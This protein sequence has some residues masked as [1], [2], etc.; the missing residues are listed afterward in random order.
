MT[1]AHPGYC[2]RGHKLTSETQYLRTKACKLCA[3]KRVARF[4]QTHP[5]Y[6]KK[7]RAGHRDRTSVHSQDARLKLR[8]EFLDAYGGKC[9]CCGED[10]EVFLTLEHKRGDGIAHRAKFGRSSTQALRDL[11]RRGWPQKHYGILCW[12]C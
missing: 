5:R 4:R 9:E 1:M 7:W 2:K 11:K 12:N 6:M 10:R 3:R 8:R